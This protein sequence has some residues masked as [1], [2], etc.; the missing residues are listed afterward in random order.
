MGALL[1][2]DALGWSRED[3]VPDEQEDAI[4]MRLMWQW[5]AVISCADLE[6]VK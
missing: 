6:N 1:V 5:Q 4:V 3:S 2:D